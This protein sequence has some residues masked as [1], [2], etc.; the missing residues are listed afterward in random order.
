MGHTSL[1]STKYYYSIVP[2]LANL[3]E[4]KSGNSFDDLTPEVPSYEE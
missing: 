2:A 1:E 3:I 4:E